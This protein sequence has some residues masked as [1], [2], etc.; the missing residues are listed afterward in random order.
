MNCC[1]GGHSHRAKGGTED[2]QKAGEYF[3][4]AIDADPNYALAY[5]DLSDI[6]RSLINS[7][8]LAPRPSICPKRRA[9]AQK[10]LELDE[11][12]A[13]GHYALANLMTY[14]WE[15]AEAEREYKRA[16]ELNPNLA[17]GA[18]LVCGLSAPH[19]TARPG[20]RGDHS[21]E[22][23]R[24]AVAGRQRNG[25]VRPVVRWSTRPGDARR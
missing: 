17:L 21:R 24:S 12:L 18:S 25:R 7:G 10:A 19:G 6:Y 16:I 3:R 15:W 2:R 23:A 22:G 5:A 1:S 14:A 4:Q 8:H 11:T 13:D 9:A 20:D